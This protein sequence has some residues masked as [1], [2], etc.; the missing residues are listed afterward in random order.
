MPVTSYEVTILGATPLGS[1]ETRPRAMIRLRDDAV[2]LGFIRFFDLQSIPPDTQRP[3]G[4]VILTE[5]NLPTAM[6]VP[7]MDLLRN[8]SPVVFG[9]GDGRGQLTTQVE[10]GDGEAAG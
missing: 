8:E 9:F 4:D 1:G 3:S 2:T 5:M 10:V 7:I 6:L